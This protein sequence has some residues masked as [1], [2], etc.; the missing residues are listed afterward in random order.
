MILE[1]QDGP[2]DSESELSYVSLKRTVKDKSVLIEN[3][4]PINY[5]YKV[6]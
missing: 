1:Q 2:G 5:L 4:V 6:Q 3:S